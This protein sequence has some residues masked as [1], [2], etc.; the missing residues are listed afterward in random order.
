MIPFYIANDTLHWGLIE[1]SGDIIGEEL[2]NRITSKAPLRE[3]AFFTIMRQ[4]GLPAKTIIHLRL[5]DIELTG[6]IPYKINFRRRPKQSKPKN[7]PYFIG[8]EGSR[9]INQYLASRNSLT[10]ESL[11]FVTTRDE[12]K[13]IN[14][15]NVSRT[16]RTI[17]EKINNEE[18]KQIQQKN[19][20]NSSENKFSLKSL[21]A[22]YLENA[23]YYEEAIRDNPDK[24]DYFYK[25]LYKEKALPFL[26]IESH[27]SYEITT[28]REFR[29]GMK[30]AEA[31]EKDNIQKNKKI[32]RN[33]EFISLILSLI[34]DN[35]GDFETRQNEVIGDN[36]IELWKEVKQLQYKNLNEPWGNRKTKLL[37]LLCI[38][39]ELTKT[40]ERIKKPYD[41]L[42]KQ[43]SEV[44]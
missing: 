5:K 3:K 30:Y 7:V 44:P 8:E 28:R 29:R 32:I 26:D 31:I 40:L 6:T 4:T 2:L 18:R 21:T 17:L 10:P 42:E 9:H 20:T 43:L 36:F 14:P 12:N 41:E 27:Y 38:V 35:R 22:F 19:L 25:K 23:K 15:K 37:P 11:L 16:F 13:P 24:Y 1:M 39:E 34:Y 33:N